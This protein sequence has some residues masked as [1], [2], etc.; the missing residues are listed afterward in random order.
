VLVRKFSSKVKVSGDNA[1]F[2]VMLIVMPIKTMGYKSYIMTSLFKK[3]DSW[4]RR[5]LCC[6]LWKQWGRLGYR[7]LRHRGVSSRLAWN[8]AKSAHGPWR[9]SHSPALAIALPGKYFD[10]I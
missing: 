3:L 2:P 4:I 6:Y 8:T 1:L 7:E 5:K 9:L 10:A